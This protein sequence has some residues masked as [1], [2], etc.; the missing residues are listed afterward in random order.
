VLTVLLV[1][2]ITQIID[3]LLNQLHEALQ[4]GK[5]DTRVR[6]RKLIE[7]LLILIALRRLTLLVDNIEAVL[8]CV[9]GPSKVCHEHFS[10]NEVLCLRLEGSPFLIN[11]FAA[12]LPVD[13][14]Q[15]FVYLR[16]NLNPL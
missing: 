3:D 13:L 2:L 1:L 10:A 16:E 9:Q 11:A 6:F 8:D 14:L 7:C 4:I 12:L 15:P 5:N